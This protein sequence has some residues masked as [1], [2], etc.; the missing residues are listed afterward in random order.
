MTEVNTIGQMVDTQMKIAYD[1][2]YEAGTIEA[3]RILDDAHLANEVM[4]AQEPDPDGEQTF[5]IPGNPEASFDEKEA[6]WDSVDPFVGSAFVVSVDTVARKKR[7]PYH[8]HPAFWK[9]HTDSFIKL[10]KEGVS[11]PDDVF[12]MLLGYGLTHKAIRSK[13]HR[14]GYGVNNGKF[15]KYGAK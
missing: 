7:E 4:E 10:L 11:T 1:K 8:S 2:G 13:A 6:Y 14:L 12:D 15:Y 9:A 5:D 3:L